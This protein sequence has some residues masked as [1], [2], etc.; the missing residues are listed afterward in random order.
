MYSLTKCTLTTLILLW[1][2]SS[3][4]EAQYFEGK[5]TY[6]QS[7]ESKL[8]NVTSEQFNIMMGNTSEYYIKGQNYKT[9]MNGTVSEF[10]LYSPSENRLYNKVSVTDTLLW[11][12]ASSNPYKVIEYS[13][14]KSNERIL[15]YK[16]KVLEVVTESGKTI[17]YFSK[18]LKINPELYTNHHFGN[19]ALF[20]SQTKSLPLKVIID[21]TQFRSVGVVTKIEEMELMAEFFKLPNMPRKKNPH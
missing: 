5:L 3:K 15:G 14:A 16:C 8:P 4:L 17:Y 12:D 21:N 6:S 11:N 1:V 10:Q 19:W 18:K 2:F 9:V 13:I 7:Y 20:T